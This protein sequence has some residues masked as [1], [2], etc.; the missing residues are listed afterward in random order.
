MTSATPRAAS[1]LQRQIAPEALKAAGASVS[2]TL[3]RVRRYAGWLAIG[4]GVSTLALGVVVGV[5]AAMLHAEGWRISI[6]S[7]PEYVAATGIVATAVSAVVAVRTLRM[8][9]TR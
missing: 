1:V 4:F 8:A 7:L 9:N 2:A 5:Q 3:R 6:G